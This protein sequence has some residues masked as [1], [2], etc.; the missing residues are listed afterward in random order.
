MHCFI[1]CPS[2]FMFNSVA[3]DAGIEPKTA[4]CKVRVDNREATSHLL[5]LILFSGDIAT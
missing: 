5:F 2:T 3:K 4:V 1:Y